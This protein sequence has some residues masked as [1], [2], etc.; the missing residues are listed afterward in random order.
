[1][2]PSFADDPRLKVFVDLMPHAHFAPVISGWEDV[3]HDVINA[4]Q[5][6][7]LGNAQPEAALKSAA[8]QANQ[9]L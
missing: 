8:A 4:L 7:Y 9:V 3:A 1:M 5:S 6:V 2:D